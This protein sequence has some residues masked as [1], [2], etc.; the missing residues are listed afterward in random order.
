MV[1]G[2]RLR[3]IATMDIISDSDIKEIVSENAAAL[4]LVEIAMGSA[5]HGLKIPLGG[6]LLSLN[7][8][9][10]LSRVVKKLKN[11][12]GVY[13]FPVYVSTISAILKSLSPAGNKLAPMLSISVQGLLFSFPVALLGANFIGISIGMVFLSLW[14]FAQQFLTYYL[15]FG[16]NLIDALSFYSDKIQ[17]SISWLPFSIW[18]ALAIIVAMKAFF[19]IVVGNLAF[20]ATDDFFSRYQKILSVKKAIVRPNFYNSDLSL[21]V[22]IKL[23]SKDLTK[24]FFIF[25]ILLMGIF[26]LFTENSFSKTV[27]LLLRPLAIAFVFFYLARSPRIALLAG[28]MRRSQ[29]L[30]PFMQLFDETLNKIRNSKF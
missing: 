18:T 29:R 26:F 6:N 16:H 22:R 2:N 15:F 17:E 13:R 19:A 23:I 5:V 11:V 8:G 21:S 7:Q 3:L 28:R 20:Y 30:A 9:A 25:S 10:F 4:A 14:S 24:P 12:D 27:W 1:K